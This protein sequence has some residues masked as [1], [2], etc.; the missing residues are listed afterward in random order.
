MYAK[1]KHFF[2]F[3][4]AFIGL[5]V[6]APVFLVITIILY[7]DLKES[8]FFLQKR[9]GKN[10]VIFFI[11]KYKTMKNTKNDKGVLL[12]DELRLTKLG[13]FIRKASLD[14]IPQLI[15]VLKG[16]M[17]FVGPRPLLESYLPLYDKFQQ[18]RHL[19]KPGIT[20]WTQVNGRNSNTWEQ[21]FEYDV[22]YVHNMSLWLDIKILFKTVKKV[23]I[24]E[25][26][27]AEGQATASAFT[28]TI[29]KHEN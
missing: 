29:E 15:N 22:W 1:F 5:L 7:F 3:I 18:Q 26:I 12:P 19:V 20:G 10:D 21:K 28:G 9:V 2:D 16:E 8:P 23:F 25:G 17:S 14:E 13:T 27:S 6:L 4:A 24:S 11:V